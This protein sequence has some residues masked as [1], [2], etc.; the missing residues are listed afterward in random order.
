MSNNSK[1]ILKIEWCNIGLLGDVEGMENNIYELNNHVIYTTTYTP[2]QGE[3][4]IDFLKEVYAG[5]YLEG[6]KFTS[7]EIFEK[8]W[9]KLS[10]LGFA[11]IKADKMIDDDNIYP[12]NVYIV[13]NMRS[14]IWRHLYCN[15]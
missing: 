8:D 10:Q 11:C 1:F 12:K 2:I 6:D 4:G 14:K 5:D 15:D 7:F 9:I 3:L 13:E